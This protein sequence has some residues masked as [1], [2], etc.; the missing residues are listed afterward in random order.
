M[1]RQTIALFQYQL[2]GIINTRMIL[3]LC[4]I[5]AV[6]FL[7]SRFVAELAIINSEP[8]ALAV[9]AEFLRY[10]LILMMILSLCFQVSQDYELNLFDRLLAMPVSRLQ[11][12]LA[13]LGVLLTLGLLL[14]VP[15]FIMMSVVNDMDLAL[16]WALSVY[17]ELI[18]VGQFAVLAILSLEKLP[19]AVIFTLAAY[20][21]AKSSPVI[22]I[23]FSQSTVFY[24][25]ES[26]FQFS[27][28]IFSIVQYVLPGPNAFAQNNLLLELNGTWS[29]LTQQL[30]TVLIYGTFIQFVIL[31]DFYR[32]E[33][34]QT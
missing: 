7:G 1:I 22:D 10:S 9:M 30:I 6:A 34:N 2:S 19:V 21:L 3:M 32:K 25:D 24:E 20:L 11:Y 15:I 27:A 23:I 18:L 8:I 17:L 5:L 28:F 31:I 12:V 33:F 26:S 16:Y 29:A 13:E 14:T 4:A